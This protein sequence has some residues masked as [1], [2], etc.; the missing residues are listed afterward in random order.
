MTAYPDRVKE[1]ST[2][3]GTGN[4]TL[5]GA[6]TNFQTFNAAIGQGIYFCYVIEHQ[7]V[8]E[9]ETGIGYLSGSTTL[10]RD[11]VR[12]SSNGGALVNLSAGTKNVFVTL[13]G[14]EVTYSG[15]NT[16]IR[17]MLAGN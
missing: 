12:A 6:A 15:L 10:V 1:T 16:A 14:S 5:A 11:R 4:L 2:T 7:S 17:M 8:A 13:I 3:T 9:W